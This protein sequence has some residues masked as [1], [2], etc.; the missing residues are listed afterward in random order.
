MQ[1]V[2]NY[3]PHAQDFVHICN[4]AN[5][6]QLN[7]GHEKQKEFWPGK[8]KQT[9]RFSATV[10]VCVGFLGPFQTLAV[11]VKCQG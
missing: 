4:P 9:G 8:C 5:V 11:R 7:K 10:R 6:L 2:Q 1:H 3:R